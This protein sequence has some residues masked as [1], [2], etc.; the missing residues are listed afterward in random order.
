MLPGR[1]RLLRASHYTAARLDL[2]DIRQHLVVS[3][4]LTA[5]QTNPWVLVDKKLSGPLLSSRPQVAFGA[6]IGNLLQLQRS[7]ERVR[8]SFM[9]GVPV[10]Q[11]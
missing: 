3:L 9:F 11:E 6:Y 5:M 7:F 2:L 1:L 8:D 10:L 4:G